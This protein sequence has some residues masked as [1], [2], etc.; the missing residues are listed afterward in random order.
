MI[1]QQLKV[2]VVFVV[3][4]AAAAGQTFTLSATPLHEGGSYTISVHGPADQD[5]HIGF[6]SDAGPTPTSIGTFALGFSSQFFMIPWLRTNA[7]GN[8]SFTGAGGTALEGEIIHVQA[9]INDPASPWGAWISNPY[10]GGIHP[11]LPAGTPVGQTLSDDD[12][13]LVDLGMS[14]PFYGTVWTECHVGSNGL[15]TFGAS[16]FDPTEQISDFMAGVPKI[17]ALWDDLSPQIQGSVH[18]ESGAG[19]FRAVWTDVPQFYVLDSNDF[20][21]TL[22]SDGR[23]HLAWPQVDLQDGMIGIG[24]GYWLGTP[25]FVDFTA[26]AAFGSTAGAGPILEQFLPSVKPFDL[27]GAAL[28]LTPDGVGGYTWLR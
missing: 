26:T 14:F 15:V 3:L 19:W 22:W 21:L 17:A 1:K 6:D 28:T 20:E 23:I 24:P 16:N 4:A 12:S 5:W 8:G 13:V 18:T 9:A 25:T 27:E 7:A 11:P 10:A 2:S